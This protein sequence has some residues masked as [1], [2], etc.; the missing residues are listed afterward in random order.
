[1]RSPGRI[2][3]IL[4]FAKAY[5]PQPLQ[6]FNLFNASTASALVRLRRVIERLLEIELL[7]FLDQLRIVRG[8]DDFFVLQKIDKVPLRD[9]LR[10]LRIVAQRNNFWV[11][12]QLVSDGKGE[13]SF[14]ALL[15]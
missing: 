14:S 3:W 11:L 2:C 13:K 9:H 4:A 7:Q 10:D 15:V 6:R 1:M 12:N 8:I 5:Q